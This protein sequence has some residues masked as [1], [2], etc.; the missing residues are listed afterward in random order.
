MNDDVGRI[1]E[2]NADAR[3]FLND[4][5]IAGTVIDGQTLFGELD[6]NGDEYR[7]SLINADLAPN[8]RD[9]YNTVPALQNLEG[10]TGHGYLLTQAARETPQYFKQIGRNDTLRFFDTIEAELGVL[11]S[12]LDRL[13]ADIVAANEAGDQVRRDALLDQ[14][15]QLEIQANTLLE[16]AQGATYDARKAG[17][18]TLDDIHGDDTFISKLQNSAN[19]SLDFSPSSA[20]FVSSLR[21]F[22]TKKASQSPVA[23]NA[24]NTG[25]APL[26]EGYRE[27]GSVGAAGNTTGGLPAGYRRVVS[28]E[29]DIEILAPSGRVYAS[30]DELPTPSGYFS[31]RYESN[32]KH[33]VRRPGVSPQPTNPETA[34]AN[35]VPVGGNS[36]GRIAY[37]D[38]TGEIVV[39]QNH[40]G[41][42]YH[43]YTVAWGDLRQS[44][45]N[46]LVNA[47]L[48]KPNGK[49]K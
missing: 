30:V 4:L 16:S 18:L 13:H 41:S 14:Q 31:G 46:A 42:N 44:Q 20:F 48:F 6:T 28:G 27:L 5:D 11:A 34:L 35:S 45:K 23:N 37:D 2:L 7:N 33:D 3:A 12:G 24:G 9:L 15:S 19:A 25:A 22:L 29:G 49:P 8:L 26:P 38:S 10:F 1:A 39:F 32:P 36:T 40:Q 21:K 43:G 47:G 17:V